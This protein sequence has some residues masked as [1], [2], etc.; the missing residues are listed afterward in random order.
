MVLASMVIESKLLRNASKLSVPKLM[1]HSFGHV[2][3][4]KD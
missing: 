3:Q 2:L 1:H 4:I